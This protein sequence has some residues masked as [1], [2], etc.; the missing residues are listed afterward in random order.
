MADLYFDL[1]LQDIEN[2]PDKP[3]LIII[4]KGENSENLMNLLKNIIK[5]L[6]IDFES[7]CHV[8]EHPGSTI[9]LKNPGKALENIL[10]FGV[11]YE[12]I[13]FHLKSEEFKIYTMDKFKLLLAPALSV[14]EKDQQKK[15]TLWKWLQ[16]MFNLT[17]VQ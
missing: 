2:L 10:L 13:G 4:E 8:L 1:P 17:K 3:L 11:G 5:A 12:A 16:V 7:S 9:H 14:L 6:K 15:A